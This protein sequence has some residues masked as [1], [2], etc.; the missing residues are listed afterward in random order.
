MNRNFR[1][2]EISTGNKIHMFEIYSLSNKKYIYIY[3]YECNS[4]FLCTIKER[5]DSRVS[6]RDA[7][8]VLDSFRRTIKR[9]FPRKTYYIC[10]RVTY[11]AVTVL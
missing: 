9:T 8:V 7:V 5:G 6:T 2:R 3:I 10:M 4:A 1:V 11:I